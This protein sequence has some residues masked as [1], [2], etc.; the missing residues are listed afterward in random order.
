M[1]ET[2]PSFRHLYLPNLYW[3]DARIRYGLDAMGN[4]IEE[5]ERDSSGGLSALSDRINAD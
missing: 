3:V 1:W 2:S 4:R 5:E